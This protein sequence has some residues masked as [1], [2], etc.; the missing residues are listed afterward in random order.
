MYDQFAQGLKK[1]W[2]VLTFSAFKI[3]QKEIS[4]LLIIEVVAILVIGFLVSK[5]LRRL[6]KGRLAKT[7]LD[8]GVQ[9]TILQL[10][11]YSISAIVIYQAIMMLGIRL[12]G[13]AFFAGILSVGIGFGLQSIANNFVSGLILLFE[14][15]VKVGDM[16]TAGDTEGRVQD[17]KMR[18]TQVV[19]RDNVSIIVP[20]SQFISGEVTNWSHRDP[21]V[22]IH[23][24]VGVAYG[25]DV[26]LVTELLLKVAKAHP[27][28]MEEPSPNVWFTAFG[29]SSLNFELL[30]WIGK[31]IIRKQ[32]TSDLNYAI[33]AVFRENEVTIPFPQRDLHLHS[34]PPAKEWESVPK[35][36]LPT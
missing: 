17:I 27:Q 36:N 20:N 2:D 3:G 18:A 24:P 11:H 22:R 23:I 8:E 15:P 25:S 34:L 16:I 4:L 31:P 5:Q 7:R 33:D 29:D 13:L 14:R 9:Y 30:A 35:W 26:Q 19:T 32:V 12:T 1:S 28:V 21:K 10:I 6:I